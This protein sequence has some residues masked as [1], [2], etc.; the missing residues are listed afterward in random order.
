MAFTRADLI[1]FLTFTEGKIYG[2][3]A[4]MEKCF[5]VPDK[6]HFTDDYEDGYPYLFVMANDERSF[7]LDTASYWNIEEALEQ[8]ADLQENHDLAM[9]YCSSKGEGVKKILRNDRRKYSAWVKYYATIEK[10]RIDEMMDFIGVEP[11]EADKEDYVRLKELLEKFYSLK[12]WEK[13]SDH[14]II[15]LK[16][17]NGENVYFIVM[18]NAGKTFGLSI[19]WGP[20]ALNFI[21]SMMNR[22]DVTHDD[23]M[24]V[25]HEQQVMTFYFDIQGDVGPD[26]IEFSK[27]IGF[28]HF[29]DGNILLTSIRMCH[30]RMWREFLRKEDCLRAINWVNMLNQN[31]AVYLKDPTHHDAFED[32]FLFIR[33]LK[34]KGTFTIKNEHGLLS[35]IIKPLVHFEKQMTPMPVDEKKPKGEYYADIRSVERLFR[36]GSDRRIVCV[37]YVLFLVEKDTGRIAFAATESSGK[38]FHFGSMG[39]QVAD[40]F[41]KNGTPKCVTVPSMVAFT[42]FQELY[43]D[44]PKNVDLKVT[45]DPIPALDEA[46]EGLKKISDEALEDKINEA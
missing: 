22:E 11:Y 24:I 14:D 39:D 1:K 18:G 10:G 8:F 9:A 27:K 28:D 7:P 35:G 25:M 5:V 38:P 26:D 44:Q 33:Y 6:D 31:L 13:F 16:D 43:Y 40:F 42:F 37:P 23:A 15:H 34:T 2:Y 36:V 3:D 45:E 17:H 20:D 19:Y 32:N 21:K 30:G 12:A 4:L 29:L 46:F 41:V